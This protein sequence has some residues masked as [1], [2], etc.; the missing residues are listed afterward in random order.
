MINAY[1]VLGITPP[2]DSEMVKRAYRKRC[3]DLHP[4]HSGRVEDFIELK[5]AYQLLMHPEKRAHLGTLRI[6]SPHLLNAST[7]RDQKFEE[8]LEWESGQ[9]LRKGAQINTTA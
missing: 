6:F 9:S 4:D 5:R 7:T 3:L 8:L 1:E 2:A